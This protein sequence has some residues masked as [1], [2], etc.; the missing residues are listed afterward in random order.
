MSRK[1][2]PGCRNVAKNKE[3]QAALVKEGRPGEM[4]A[5]TSTIAPSSPTIAQLIT[6]A[7]IIQLTLY[8]KHVERWNAVRALK[9]GLVIYSWLPRWYLSW[10]ALSFRLT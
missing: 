9:E 10:W 5:S 3:V 4:S 2:H 1:G 6:L 7:N 8:H